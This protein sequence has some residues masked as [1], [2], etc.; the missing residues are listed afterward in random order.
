MSSSSPSI[1]P[2]S[3][4]RYR[5]I[6]T[7]L[8]ASVPLLRISSRRRSQQAEPVQ[9]T[10]S[11]ALWSALIASRSSKSLAL[12]VGFGM[13]LP[14]LLILTGQLLIGWGQVTLDTWRY[15]FP[16]TYQTNAYVGQEG[17]SRQPSHFIAIN[18]QGQ[19]EVIELPGNDPAHARIFLG[20][21][22]LGH[23]ADLLPLTLSF[24][25]PQHTHHPDMLVQFGNSSI[26]FVNRQ[27]T[28]QLNT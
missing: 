9:T 14:I 23:N 19:I 17:V 7:E 20:P 5:P 15:G 13:S 12:F 8:N 22:M 4:V 28:F 1:C 2:R 16:R 21:R 25:D 18:N 24:P 6:T 26:H 3:A 11:K 27:G 10:R